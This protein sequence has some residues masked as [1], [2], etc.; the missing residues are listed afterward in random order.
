MRT[1]EKHTIKQL[2]RSEWDSA[3]PSLYEEQT[4]NHFMKD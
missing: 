1:S 4:E 2:K 3:E